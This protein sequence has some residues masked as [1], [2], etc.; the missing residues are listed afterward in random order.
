MPLSKEVRLLD[1]R[2][3]GNAGWPKR[4]EW[5]EITGIRGW[6]GE[7]VEFPFPITALVG[8]NG[9]GKSTVLQAVAACYRGGSDNFASDFFPDTPW[10]VIEKAE[11]RVC[12]REGPT[13]GSIKTSVISLRS[14]RR[15]V[16][17]LDSWPSTTTTSCGAE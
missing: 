15:G 5:I 8:E 2:W 12:M 1:A 14:R 11:I 4:L 6:I 9:V 13:S 10:E 7:R 16:M 17:A 3:K